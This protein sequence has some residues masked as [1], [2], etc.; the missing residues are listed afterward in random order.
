MVRFGLELRKERFDWGLDFQGHAKTAIPLRIAAPR[1]R[2]SLRATDVA[3]AL[4][5]RPTPS[6]PSLAHIVERE[7]WLAAKVTHISLPSSPILPRVELQPRMDS[8]PL[9]TVQMGTG[10]QGKE[11]PAD[12]MSQAMRLL[13]A[14]GCRVVAL[15]GPN[16]P[17]PEAGEDL[18]GRTDLQQ[19]LSWIK[20]SRVHLA[21]DTGTGHMAAALGVPVVSIFGPEDPEKCRPWGLKVTVLKQGSRTSDVSPDQAASAVMKALE[22]GR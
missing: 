19:T 9:V 7:A 6:P 20:S 2:L 12:L 16:D 1:S 21:P 17:H 10:W 18:V 15:G 5:A 8:R 11:Y 14:E 4:I 3:T 22:G 13:E